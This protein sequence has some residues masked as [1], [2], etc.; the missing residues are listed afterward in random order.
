MAD[1][2]PP[3]DRL[4]GL[5]REQ[6]ALLFEQVRR[7]KEKARAA[8]LPAGIPRRPPGL[9]PLPLSFAQER[10][11]FIDRMQPGLSAYNIPQALLI[12]GETSPAVFA[13][14]LGEVVRRHEVLR[15]TFREV[16]GQPVQVIAPAGLWTLPLVDLSALPAELRGAQ[17]K[18]LAQEESDRPFDLAR[19]PLLRAVF[20]RLAPAEHALLLTMHHIVSDGWSMGV[21]VREIS[22]L[23][24]AARAG[25]PSPLP[26]LPIQY[27][28]FAVWQ[29]GWLR[30][31]VLERQLAYWREKLAGVPATLDLPTDRPLPA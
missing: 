19:G 31:E 15:T 20:L 5:S 24:G 27:A 2:T 17:A 23:Y 7:R 18:A 12:T 1:P 30:G 21:L 14:L 9:E 25:S 13:A 11:W 28:D 3:Q 16:D 4:A 10:L 8:A 6:R 26:E 22:A 29:R